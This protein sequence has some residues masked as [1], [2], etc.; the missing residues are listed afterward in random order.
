MGL[1]DPTGKMSKS[2]AS[3]Y[4]AVYLL[5]SPARAKKAIMR[6]VTDSGREITFSND[7]ERAGVNNLLNIYQAITVEPAKD[8]EAF[9][10]GKGYGDLKKAVAEQVNGLLAR[11]QERYNEVV[12][13]TGYLDDVLG[14]GAARAS[15]VANNTLEDVRNC[16]GLLPS[17]RK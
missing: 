8:I 15:A 5:D 13:E 12:N 1:D 11:L 10:A 2:E 7:P 6:A 3:E 16:I 9:F 4:H 14:E 17:T